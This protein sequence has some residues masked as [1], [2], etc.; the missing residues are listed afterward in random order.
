MDGQLFWWR[1]RSYMDGAS[2]YRVQMGCALSHWHHL[3]VGAIQYVKNG[4]VRSAQSFK[5]SIITFFHT[6]KFISNY[7]IHQKSCCIARFLSCYI[8]LWNS[9]KFM[10]KLFMSHY[11]VHQWLC[12]NATYIKVYVRL[13][14]KTTLLP[15]ISSH[16][17]SIDIKL[18]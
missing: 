14:H 16:L 3:L 17:Y 10:L 6:T 4:I 7:G 15:I 11:D 1:H 5:L 13:R 12:H 8:S 9:P 2:F 18:K